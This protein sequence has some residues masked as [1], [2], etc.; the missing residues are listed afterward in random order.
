MGRIALV[1]G[2]SKGVGRGIACGLADDGWDVA[3]NY[4]SDEAG[5]RETAACVREKGRKAWVLRADVGYGGQV[6]DMFAELA[7]DAGPIDLLVN[8]AGVQTWCS[9][10]ELREEDWDRTIRT[11]LKGTFLCTQQAARAMLGRGGSIVNIGSGCNHVPFPHLVD[12]TASKGGIDNFTKIAAVEL[13]PFGIRVNCVA[14]GA[15]EIER[16]KLESPD[17]AGTWGPMAPLK[18]VGQVEDVARA[19]AFFASEKASFITGQTLFVDGGLFTQA[20]WP[21]PREGEIAYGVPNTA[22]AK[23]PVSLP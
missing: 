14:P 9:L 22:Q 6:R 1:T 4:N 7:R 23:L 20:P 21:P 19:V 18:R 2:S 15:V 17:Y 3:V 5:A 10:F 16:T 11:N 8:N 12:Y 13:G